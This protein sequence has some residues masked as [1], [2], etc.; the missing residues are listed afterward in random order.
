MAKQSAIEQARAVIA[1]I[2]AKVAACVAR[3]AEIAKERDELSYAAHVQ[4]D[5]KSRAKL[6]RLHEEA[7]KNDHH[8]ATITAALKTAHERLATAEHEATVKADKAR[9]LALREEVVKVSE[10]MKIADEFFAAGV[11]ALVVANWAL[12]GFINWVKPTRRR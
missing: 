7:M 10:Y 1:D 4:G 3:T 9:A 8:S 2:E 11:E 12:S 6:N 5:E